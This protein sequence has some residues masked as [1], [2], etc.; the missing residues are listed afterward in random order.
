MTQNV[1]QSGIQTESGSN[2]TLDL[3]GHTITCV[4]PFVGSSEEYTNGMRFMKGSNVVIKNGTIKAISPMLAILIQN[5]SDSLVLDNVTLQ[6][7]LATQYILS[8]NYGHVTLKNNTVVK[9]SGGHVAFD[10]HYGLSEEYDD[11]CT[12]TIADNTVKIIGEVEYT[13]SDRCSEENFFAKTHI[14][15]PSDYT[16]TAPAGFEFKLTADGTQ[17][18]LVKAQ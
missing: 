4:A 2:V 18:E 5:F 9:A 1:A 10:A 12:V 6:G 11:G 15:I 8:N 16:L 3:D 14:Y 17:K 7:K 13:K